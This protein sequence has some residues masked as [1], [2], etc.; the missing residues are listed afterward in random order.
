MT[1]PDRF[2]WERALRQDPS[3]P[4]PVKSFLLLYGTYFDGD[5]GQRLALGRD[6]GEQ[7][8]AV[9]AAGVRAAERG[10]FAGVARTRKA[11]PTCRS[12]SG[13]HPRDVRQV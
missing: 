6:A 10:A 1:T 3:V 8:R 9:A 7:R 4:W 11:E 13:C 2:T 12:A 5:S